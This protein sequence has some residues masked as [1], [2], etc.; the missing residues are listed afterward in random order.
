MVFKGF[1]LL[2]PLFNSKAHSCDSTAEETSLND[3]SEAILTEPDQC[4][5]LSLGL[6]IITLEASGKAYTRG[7]GTQTDL[8]E[9]EVKTGKEIVHT[10][11]ITTQTDI[12]EMEEVKT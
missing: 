8:R 5:Q 10:R 2:F 1:D 12:I 3:L 6:D 11:D 7:Q 9:E 4:S